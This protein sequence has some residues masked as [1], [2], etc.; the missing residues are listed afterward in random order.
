MP[1]PSHRDRSF[2][3]DEPSRRIDRQVFKS[4]AIWQEGYISRNCRNCFLCGSSQHL[5]RNC[6]FKKK[7]TENC[8]FI[9]VCSTNTTKCIGAEIILH[10][11]RYVVLTDRGCSISLLSWS[12]YEKLGK[13]GTVQTYTKRE[14]TAD[15]SAAKI[16]GRKIL[17]VQLQPRLPEVEKEFVITTE[18]GIEFRLGINFLKTNKCEL[19]LQ[20]EKLF[21][22]HFK[23]S[24]QLT[25]EKTQGVKV[26]AI[27]RQ[28][29]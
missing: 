6:P 13:S 12:T 21:S 16:I 1:G 20:G 4:R 9:R 27:V 11:T 14:L 8:N 3:K 23:I 28:N 10:G 19:N 2:G 22:S 18:K 17:L 7:T 5:K 26:F 25:T 29:T 15:N 24:I